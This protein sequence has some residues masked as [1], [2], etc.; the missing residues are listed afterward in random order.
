MT[1]DELIAAL[2]KA[3]GPDRWLD[4][5]IW[6]AMTKPSG[7]P[8]LSEPKENRKRW[9]ETWKNTDA[10]PLYSASIDAALT[11]VPEGWSWR[12]GNLPSG[13]G[14]ADLGTQAS[15]QCIEGATPAI[16]LCIAAL[17]ARGDRR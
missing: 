6:C 17:K 1:D 16:S 11:L 12:A 13:K 4:F 3:T 9:F 10:I 8:A 5:E 7:F 2:E 14:F 15:L